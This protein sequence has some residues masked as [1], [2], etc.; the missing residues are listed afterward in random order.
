MKALRM[1]LKKPLREFMRMSSDVLMGNTK[2]K[3]ASVSKNHEDAK[4]SLTVVFEN[5]F[6]LEMSCM[7]YWDSAFVTLSK[8]CSLFAYD[9]EDRDV[10]R[11]NIEHTE[12]HLEAYVT[13]LRTLLEK[14]G[15][16]APY[17]LVGHSLG[18]LYVQYFARKYPDEVSG[19]VLVD[20]THSEISL[21]YLEEAS[22]ENKIIDINMHKI[23]QAVLN[24][25]NFSPK[26]MVILSARQEESKKEA[27]KKD[28]LV[29]MNAIN[30]AI[31]KQKEL[32]DLYPLAKHTWV[33]CGH[34]I[35]YEKPGSVVDAVLEIIFKIG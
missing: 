30:L 8:E 5:G 32:G 27:S 31:K 33:G 35:Q 3:C 16:K 7:K 15:L 14:K 9:R 24:L 13:N 18:G 19:I 12:E 34:H 10:A 20:A 11:A 22:E 6:C 25:A 1:L 29:Q 26:P 28:N 21:E 4:G 17:V 2:I 23:G